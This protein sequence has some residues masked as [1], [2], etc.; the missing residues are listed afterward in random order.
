VFDFLT[1]ILKKVTK[2]IILNNQTVVLL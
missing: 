1:M 2:K